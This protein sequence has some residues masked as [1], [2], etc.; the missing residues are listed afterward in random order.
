MDAATLY[1]IITMLD[2]RERTF[3][4]EYASVAQCEAVRAKM[5][6][7]SPSIKGQPTR[8]SCER[9]IRISPAKARE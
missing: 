3:R 6:E 1:T 7:L 8:Y 2:G 5:S 9:H 4:R